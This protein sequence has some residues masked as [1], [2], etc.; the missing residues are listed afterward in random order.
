[1]SIPSQ[2]YVLT[3]GETMALMRADQ[4]GPLSHASSLGLGIGGSESNMAIGLQ[5]LGVQAV[6]C[7]RVGDDALGQLVIREI[8]AEGV[9]VRAAVDP[10]AP[11]GLMIKERRTPAIQ[12]VS[13]YRRDSAG[14]RISPADVDEA[15][16]AGAALLHVSGIT[17]A[18]STQAEAT[19]RYAVATARAAGVPVSSDDTRVH[20]PDSRRRRPE[21]ALFGSQ[22]CRSP[23]RS[24]FG[25]P[26]TALEAVALGR[27]RP[28]TRRRP[29]RNQR[30]GS[31]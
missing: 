19:L 8:R 1:M 31:T 16:I 30:R 24:R 10:S 29:G 12:R 25:S 28:D 13:Y 22:G 18:L 14:S 5:R 11:T 26:T 15:L 7:S 17:P 23:R 4:P 3:F 20:L 21:A 6:W 9:E 27:P 2:P